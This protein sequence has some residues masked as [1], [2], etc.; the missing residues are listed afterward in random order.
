MNIEWAVS[1][2]VRCGTELSWVLSHVRIDATKKVRGT[3]SIWNRSQTVSSLVI[4]ASWVLEYHSRY[5][6][7]PN[8]LQLWSMQGFVTPAI[9]RGNQEY[10]RQDRTGFEK[11]MRDSVKEM[12]IGPR[13]RILLYSNRWD[14]ELRR[15]ESKTKAQPAAPTKGG[16]EVV[17]LTSTEKRLEHGSEMAIPIRQHRGVGYNPPAGKPIAPPPPS[18]KP[19]DQHRR[20]AGIESEK[21]DETS[22]QVDILSQG[23]DRVCYEKCECQSGTHW[24]GHTLSIWSH[25]APTPRNER[26][27]LFVERNSHSGVSIIAGKVNLSA[28]PTVWDERAPK[29]PLRRLMHE[30]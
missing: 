20:K 21:Y 9:L 13:G 11:R 19:S 28:L 29:V 12:L 27:G 26:I 30:H 25:V 8:K 2:G 7:N 14:S 22:L 17:M 10:E 1:S 18:C 4:P 15:K 3:I 6:S 23:P 24:R 16:C 5:M